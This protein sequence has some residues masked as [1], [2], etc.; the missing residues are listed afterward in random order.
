MILKRWVK[1][2]AG[3]FHLTLR[4]APRS[5]YPGCTE[6]VSKLNSLRSP[7]F[8]FS[9]Q[10]N[11]RRAIPAHTD[12]WGK[13]VLYADAPPVFQIDCWVGP[14]NLGQSRAGERAACFSR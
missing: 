4:P 2:T 13:E 6:G 9:T 14:A 11:L 8:N 3:T 12:E 10:P 1:F 7:K 5:R